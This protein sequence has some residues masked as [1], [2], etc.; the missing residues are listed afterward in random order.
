[1]TKNVV[2]FLFISFII[3]CGEIKEEK[4][5]ETPIQAALT[6][7]EKIEKEH[8]KEAFLK[9]DNIQFDLALY[10]GGKQRINGQL[11]LATNSSQ[12][13]IAL[14][15]GEKVY[16]IKDKVFYSPGMNEKRVRFDAYTWSYFFLFPY[17]MSDQGTIW[18]GSEKRTMDEV[19]YNYQKLSFED[20]T[21]DDPNDWYKVYSDTNTNRISAAAYIVTASS[22]VEK[23]EEDPHAIAYSNYKEI[24][25]IPIAAEWKFFGWTEKEGLTDTLGNA[26]LSNFKFVE[27]SDSLFT[28]PTNFLS[29]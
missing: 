25:G 10:F 29:L 7:V 12:G 14:E 16:F 4:E 3:S 28:P 23:A 19:V 6:L 22:S 13:L 24:E 9:H 11:T 2:I 15:S 20:G 17:K 27:N 26:A 5:V 1:M 18:S 21:G 8:Q